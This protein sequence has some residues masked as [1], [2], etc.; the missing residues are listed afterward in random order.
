MSDTIA[1]RG[2]RAYGKHG[3]LP[4]ERDREQPFD[5]D[6]ELEIDLS[7]AR[8]SDALKDTVDYAGAYERVVTIVR[9]RS[10]ALLER[11]GDEIANDLLRDARIASAR[12]TIGKPGLLDG[13]TPSVTVTARRG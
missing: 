1:L 10:Y 8:A 3:A 11:L 5:V 6:L 4:G 7:A 12:V 2:I 9:E 13:A